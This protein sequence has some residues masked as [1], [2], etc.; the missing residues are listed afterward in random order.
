M[1]DVRLTTIINELL[2]TADQVMSGRLLS[3]G[4]PPLDALRAKVKAAVAMPRSVGVLDERAPFL[5]DVLALII[6]KRKSDDQRAVR[7][8]RQ[9]AGLMLPDLQE[10]LFAAMRREAERV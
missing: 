9:V 7:A 1:T 10:D 2:V 4:E 6:A 3:L 5:I 8:W